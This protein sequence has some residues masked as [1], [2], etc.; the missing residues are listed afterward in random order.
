[1]SYKSPLHILE[2][3]DIDAIQLSHQEIIRLRKKLLAEFNLSGSTTIDINKRE[4]TKDEI[5]GQIDTLKNLD[6]LE[7]HLQLYKNKEILS[8]CE[9]PK[10]APNPVKNLKVVFDEPETTDNFKDI[11]IDAELT[12]LKINLKNN[13]YHWPHEI[14]KFLE[15]IKYVGADHV[16]GLL[17]DNLRH[18]ADFINELDKDNYNQPSISRLEFLEDADFY[19]YLNWLPDEL[20]YHRTCIVVELINLTVR[21]QK[22]DIK[23]VN[24]VSNNLLYVD[25]EPE[26]KQLIKSNNKAFNGLSEEHSQYR[27]L[28]VV[29]YLI[30]IALR[31]CS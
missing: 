13:H 28:W 27:W 6:D 20:E 8:F 16:F 10:K 29:I 23:F 14:L 17:D 2:S 15:A 24:H 1:M 9:Q 11:V 4:Y 3:F 31:T 19:S 12:A 26:H 25:C 7:S 18:M 21:L 30:F 22:T 5:I